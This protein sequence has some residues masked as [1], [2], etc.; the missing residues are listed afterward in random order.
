MEQESNRDVL[1]IVGVKRLLTD[2]VKENKKKEME[3]HRTY[4]QTSS[5]TAQYNNLVGDRKIPLGRPGN[6]FFF[7]PIKKDGELGIV[8]E[9]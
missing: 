8:V 3:N 9:H 6:T 7:R 5:T 4:T 1:G 2:T